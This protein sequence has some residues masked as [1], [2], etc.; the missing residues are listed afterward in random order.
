MKLSDLHP[1]RFFMTS[2]SYAQV[3][4]N[5]DPEQRQRLEADRF[6]SLDEESWSTRSTTSAAL[7]PSVVLMFCSE[8]LQ[9]ILRASSACAI[10]KS[11][12]ACKAS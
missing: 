1:A 6:D 2:H 4:H 3:W 5:A 11:C 10:F 8:T 9:A 7:M 12:F